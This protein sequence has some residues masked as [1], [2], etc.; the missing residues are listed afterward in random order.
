[1]MTTSSLEHWTGC[2]SLSPPL[3]GRLCAKR[4]SGRRPLL[5]P[6]YTT[7]RTH[8]LSLSLSYQL[9]LP[10]SSIYRIIPNMLFTPSPSAFSRSLLRCLCLIVVPVT[11]TLKKLHTCVSG[12]PTMSH[13]TAAHTHTQRTIRHCRCK[14]GNGCALSCGFPFSPSGPP[15][16]LHP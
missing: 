6:L 3:T 12:W 8:C 10:L 9:T 1:M 7:A 14:V 4:H 13:R 5:P 2:S 11:A 15:P 16:A